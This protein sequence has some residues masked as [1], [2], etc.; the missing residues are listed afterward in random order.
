MNQ[1]NGQPEG[2]DSLEDQSTAFQPPGRSPRGTR[3]HSAGPKTDT[4]GFLPGTVLADRYRIVGLVGRGGMGEVYRADDLKLGQTV[5]LKFLPKGRER[6]PN[7]LSYFINEVRVSLR[8]S[9]PN[10][11]RVYDIGEVDGRPYFSMEFVDG[12]NLASLLLRI[13]RLPHDKAL[14]VAHQL[15]AGLAAAHTQGVLHRDLKPANVMIDGRGQVKVTDF[16]LAALQTG[17][18]GMGDRVG[19]PA[20]MAPE[21]WSG[22]EVTVRSDIYAL[23]LVLYELFTGRPAF[24]SRD[25]VELEKLHR[26][27]KPTP[28]SSQLAE[29]DP[30]VERVILDCLEKE[31]GD[32]P[33]SAWSVAAKLPGGDRL[34]A[35]LVAGV[36]PSPEV[37]AQARAS[38]G[39]KPAVALS[40]LL[41]IIIAIVPAVWLA[42]NRQ[43]VRMVPLNKHPAVLVEK[44]GEILRDLGYNDSPADSLFGFQL[45]EDYLAYL[46]K[47]ASPRGFDVVRSERPAAIL[48]SYR[49]SPKLLTKMAPGSLGHWFRDPP[50]TLPGMVQL[51]LDPEGRL[52]SF[53]AVPSEPDEKVEVPSGPDWAKVFRAAGLDSDSL[54]EVEPSWIP[55]VYADQRAAWDGVFPDSPATRIRLEAAAFEGRPVAFRITEPWSLPLGRSESQSRRFAS[56]SEAFRHPTFVLV[57]I[58]AVVLAWR[59]V[60]LGRGDRKGALRLALYIG[61]IRFL[62]SLGA[63]HMP[64]S[65]EVSILVAH[66]AKGLSLALVV[67]VFYL[68]LEP[69]ARRLWPRILIS[70]V[71]LLHGQW[72]DPL[73]GRD[74]LIGALIGVCFTIFIHLSRSLPDWLGLE[75][76]APEVSPLS[77]EALRGTRQALTAILALHSENVI[78]SFVN[79]VFLLLFR[80]VLRRT[81]LAAVAVSVV[82]AFALRPDSG[83]SSVYWISIALLLALTWA[84]L[85]R[86][87]LLAILV[88]MSLVDLLGQMPLTLDPSSWYWG[89]TFLTLSIILVPI[90]Y[91]F[92]ISLAGRPLFR[93]EDFRPEAVG[94]S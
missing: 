81:W 70:W 16:G 91:A 68:A 29:I 43:L 40:L 41:A 12:E 47:E 21:Q 28:P 63:H 50:P 15:C 57:L 11:C 78:G 31:P 60:R 18:E 37:V 71:R 76:F 59:N 52:I 1:S 89:V 49:Q 26:S 87:G 82:A 32:R 65:S 17:S 25:P 2:N 56:P 73:V 34:A 92:R 19:T 74:L 79:I 23:G 69:Y 51:T 44:A 27:A 85:F 39:L 94:G 22:K 24:S 58:G 86:F 33:K 20:Y 53:L 90:I 45:N 75:P 14:E 80:L 55:P 6:D 5:A 93:S 4:T 64:D 38:G 83:A 8:V 62:W 46:T 10:V 66:F 9:H 84:F 42:G 3:D 67:W 7:R 30:G 72:R 35:A 48:F 13:G 36:T 61:T 54:S 77:L 88:A